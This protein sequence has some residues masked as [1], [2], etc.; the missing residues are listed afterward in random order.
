MLASISKNKLLSIIQRFAAVEAV[1]PSAVRGQPKSTIDIVRGYLGRIDLRRIPKSQLSFRRW[2]NLHTARIERSLP[3]DNRK[4]RRR[5]GVARKTLNLFLR[6]CFYNHYLRGAYGFARIGRCLEVPI[7]S[8]VARKLREDPGPSCVPSW[9]GLGGLDKSKNEEFQ[10]CAREYA[11][12]CNLPLTV[13]L[14]NYLWLLGRGE[15]KNRR[16]RRRARAV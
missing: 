9:K 6:T 5:W 1:G 15:G 11:Q 8:V 16:V 2:L 10:Q 13:F 4:A 12:D 3:K 14:D 7:D